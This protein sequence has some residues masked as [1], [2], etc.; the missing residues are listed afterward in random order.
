MKKFNYYEREINYYETDQMGI[1]HHS[2]YAR[3][4]EECRVVMMRY[5]DMPLEMFEDM[6]YMIPVVDLYSEFKVPVRFGETIRVVPRISKVTPVKF[7]VEY[8]IYNKDMTE[9]KNISKSSHCFINMNFKPV[10]MKKEAPDLYEK[11]CGLV[12]EER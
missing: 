5:Y 8:V 2:N 10:S 11:L 9:I 4:L 12:D 3:Y 7:F 1:V 6:G